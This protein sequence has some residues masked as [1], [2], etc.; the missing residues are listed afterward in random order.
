MFAG[1][2]QTS[3]SAS[4]PLNRWWSHCSVVFV[5]IISKIFRIFEIQYVSLH[6]VWIIYILIKKFSANLDAENG[7]KKIDDVHVKDEANNDK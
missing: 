3:I 5:S 4:I 1:C 7:S 6:N 2:L